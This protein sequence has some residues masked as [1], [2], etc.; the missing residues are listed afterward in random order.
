MHSVQ[1]AFT[2]SLLIITICLLLLNQLDYMKTQKKDPL[3]VCNK[4]LLKMFC[5]NFRRTWNVKK[6][7]GTDEPFGTRAL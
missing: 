2:P 6:S 5:N 1:E 4:E 3:G 7:T